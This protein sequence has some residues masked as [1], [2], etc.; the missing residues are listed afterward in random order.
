MKRIHYLVIKSFIGPL[1][2]TFFL[3]IFIL[4][5]QFLWKYID[6]LVGK[7][8]E[9][10]VLGEFLLY[11]SASMVPMALPLAVPS[12]TLQMAAMRGMDITVARP[13][14]FALPEVLMNKSREAANASGGSIVESD[15]PA[16]AMQDAHVIYAKSWSFT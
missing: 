15:N 11:S 2:L 4:L 1:I 5:M 9:M 8:L 13:E 14:G 6:D 7:G 12:S 3:V 16:E 10:K